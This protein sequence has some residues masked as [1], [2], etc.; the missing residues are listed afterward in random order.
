MFLDT[1]GRFVN[2]LTCDMFIFL[3]IPVFLCHLM[4]RKPNSAN[5][6]TGVAQCLIVTAQTQTSLEPDDRICSRDNLSLFLF[7]EKKSRYVIYL[8]FLFI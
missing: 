3:I 8:F 5:I 2:M 4:S 7:N 6:R 1:D